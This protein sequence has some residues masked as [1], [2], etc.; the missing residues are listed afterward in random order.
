MTVEKDLK[1]YTALPYTL[2]LRPDEVG[3][4]IARI[5]ELPGCIAHGEN[6]AEA[7]S[8]IREVQK[9][10][11]ETNIENGKPIPEPEP[12]TELPSGKWLQ[13]VPRTLH[14]RLVQ[15]AREEEVSLNHLVVALVTEALTAR[16]M[17]IGS[18]ASSIQLM[19]SRSMCVPHNRGS[20]Q[21]KPC[22]VDLFLVSGI[23]FFL[24][25]SIDIIMTWVDKY[26][27]GNHT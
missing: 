5:Q 18:T 3:D 10:W 14:K 27:I 23:I 19:P 1:Y 26:A 2:I 11:I 20:S 16:L 15:A 17:K 24:F 9:L 21:I 22:Y 13:R 4:V 6:E 12:D 8:N 25:K 7:L